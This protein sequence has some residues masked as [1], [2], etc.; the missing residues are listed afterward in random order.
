MDIERDIDPRAQIGEGTRVWHHAQ[1]R[2]GAVLGDNCVIGRGA[3]IGPGVRVGANCKVQNYALVYDPARLGDG[4]FIGPA[5]VLTNDR[6]PR[7]VAPD[8]TLRRADDWE[9]VGVTIGDGASIGARSVCVAPVTE[10]MG[11]ERSFYKIA[12]R[13]GKP[14]MAGKLGRAAMLGLPG[15]PVSSIVCGHVFML[16]M[17]RA[18]QGLPPAPAP[19]LGARLA[20]PVDAN[21]PRAHDMRA[22]LGR[23]AAGTTI[24]PFGRQDSALLSILS[25]ADALLVRPANDPARRPGEE[26]DYVPV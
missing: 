16:P 2:E 4:V 17:L 20:A 18:M 21:G 13:P 23:D 7:A 25:E 24:T 12:I 3:Y 26:V 5:V 1:V 14:L 6:Y 8:G 15:N 19:R 10:A 22:R 11:M 9:P